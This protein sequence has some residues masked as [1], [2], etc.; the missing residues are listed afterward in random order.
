M[1]R[2]YHT[3]KISLLLMLI[4][5]GFS[6]CE[7]N[8]VG[9]ELDVH[10]LTVEIN[11][12]EWNPSFRRYECLFIFDEITEDVYLNGFVNAQVF[13]LEND[14]GISYETL[15]PLPFVQSYFDAARVPYTETISYD[16]SP[17]SILFSFQLSDLQNNSQWLKR[18]KFKVSIMK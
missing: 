18:C 9:V 7:I 3:L 12:W 2:I 11:D 1:K 8:D 6:S 13:V 17:G 5:A 10:I 16:V 4:A 15:K 14:G